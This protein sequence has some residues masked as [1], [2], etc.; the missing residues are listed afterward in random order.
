MF[1][2]DFSEVADHS[3][4]WEQTTTERTQLIHS[5]LL[6]RYHET[7]D[8]LKEAL[9]EYNEAL[10]HQEVCTVEYLYVIGGVP[11]PLYVKYT[12][13]FTLIWL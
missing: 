5:V 1:Q 11:V 12:I 7:T 4:V 9:R 2:T 6:K 3:K 8:N 10:Q 13:P